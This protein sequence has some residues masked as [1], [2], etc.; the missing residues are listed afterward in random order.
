MLPLSG[1][2]LR[3]DCVHVIFAGV[4]ADP[5]DGVL[6][7]IQ[8]RRPTIQ[9]VVEESVIHGN[10]NETGHC[11]KP[12]ELP[13]R[14]FI[15]AGPRAAMDQNDGGAGKPVVIGGFKMSSSSVW[16]SATP[17]TKFSCTGPAPVATGGASGIAGGIGRAPA[18]GKAVERRRDEEGAH[19]AADFASRRL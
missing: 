2:K 3:C 13:H 14:G 6:N 15:K 9:V 1:R 12:R 18:A 11:E 8:L 5:A 10:R 17:W 4:R 16:P 19:G 7:I